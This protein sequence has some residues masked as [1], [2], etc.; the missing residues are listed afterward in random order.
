VSARRDAVDVPGRPSHVRVDLGAIAQNTRTLA[1]LV[2]PAALFAVVKADAYGH[3]AVPV[4]M[5]CLGAGARALAVALPQEAVALRSAGIDAPVLVLGPA[6]EAETRGLGALG[7]AVTLTDGESV[8]R[9]RSAA[10]RLP[11]ALRP[12]AVHLKVDTGM[13]RIGCPPEAAPALA[14]AVTEAADLA[15]AGVFTHFASADEDLAATRRQLERFVA[16]RTAVERA[17]AGRARPLWHAANSAGAVALAE[18]RLD[19]VRAGIALY[20]YPV[21]PAGASAP[22]ALRPALSVVSQVSFVKRVPAGFAVSYGSTHRTAGERVLATLPLGY[23]DGLRRGLDGMEVI[24][25]DRLV[26]IVGRVTMDQV[27]VEGPAAWAVRYGDPAVLLDAEGQ[28]PTAADWAERLGTIPYEVLTGLSP[29]L[30]R[31]YVEA[32]PGDGVRPVAPR[33]EA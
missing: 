30:P 17:L 25:G 1:D 23:A 26:P 6:D 20:G 33:S 27:V 24:V 19:A 22:P 9:A 3:G 16:A 2:R 7:V 8:A 12:L 15:L 32:G 31:R 11:A 4:A 5:A 14:V 10:A 18:A 28:G 21:L 29:R 13:G